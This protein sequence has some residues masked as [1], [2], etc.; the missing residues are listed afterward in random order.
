[1]ITEFV[2]MG[3]HA[4]S[5][6][7][8]DK[9]KNLIKKGFP[10]LSCLQRKTLMSRI[11]NTANTIRDNLKNELTSMKVKYACVTT[12]CWSVYKK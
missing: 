8:E 9:F 2:V 4:F 7:E 5:I 10:K 6:V 1:M 3:N 11:S 12:D